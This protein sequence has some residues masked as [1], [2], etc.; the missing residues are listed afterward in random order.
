MILCMDN[1][2]KYQIGILGAGQLGSFLA[3]ACCKH[4]VKDWCLFFEKD[5]DPGAI[6][7]KKN[8]I[9]L[10]SDP[11]KRK[12][13]LEKCQFIILE[14]EFYS[15]K[16]L[17]EIQVKFIP[18]IKN[19]QHF[20][21]KTAQ[22]KFFHQLGL[23]CPKFWIINDVS[24]LD[25]IDQ[26]P[27]ILKRNLFSYDGNGNRECKNYSELHQ[28]ALELGFPLLIE[29]KINIKK[30][31]SVGL[32]SNGREMI[33]LPLTE[34]FQKNH[35]CHFVIGPMNLETA[36]QEKLNNQIEKI[37]KA[38]LKGLFAFEFF[39]SQDDQIIINEG[40]ARPHNSLHITQ[41]LINHSQFDYIINL[42]V[43]ENSL[44]N[45]SFKAKMGAMINLLGKKVSVNPKLTLGPI[46]NSVAHNIY[47][48]GKKDG[49]I[50]RKLGHINFLNNELSS[51]DFTKLLDHVYEEY[52]I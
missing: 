34:T 42:C 35:I 25:N 6:L 36:L 13:Q 8:A 28:Y 27:V 19:Y 33:Q 52:T 49:R 3:D 40:A 12:K 38:N 16:E 1:Q 15:Y 43:N 18:D 24:N 21:G 10:F 29:E 30:E 7:Y 9:K 2:K 45:F 23:N 20:Y 31:F 51:N 44:E 46:P 41:D 39:I 50:G 47:L 14:S 11:N 37:K 48:Y 5:D 17:K 26:F 32:V 22:R 4:S